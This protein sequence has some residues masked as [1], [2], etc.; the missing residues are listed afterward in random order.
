MMG[1][2][3][4]GVGSYFQDALKYVH[5]SLFLDSLSLKVLEATTHPSVR[6]TPCIA[7]RN[8]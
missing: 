2:G 6:Q 5:V 3:A 8:H 7:D 1:G 4:A